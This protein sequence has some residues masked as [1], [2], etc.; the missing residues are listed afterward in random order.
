M[1]KIGKSSRQLLI[2]VNNNK[3]I[4]KKLLRNL[5][6]IKQIDLNEWFRY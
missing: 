6:K 3:I 2:I 5:I 4:L 1:F